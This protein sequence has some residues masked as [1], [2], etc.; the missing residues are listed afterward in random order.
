[1]GILRADRVSGLGG[2]NAINGSVFFG[3]GNQASGITGNNILITEESSDFTF[4]TGDFTIEG[5]FY[6]PDLSNWNLLVGDNVYG[7]GSG[8][9]SLYFN[10]DPDV[11]MWKTGSSVVSGATPTVNTWHHVAFSRESG[12]NRV[13]LDG[14]LGASASDSTNYTSNQILIGANQLTVS[15]NVSQWG[16]K[17]YASNVRVIKGEAIYTAA[18]TAPTTR[19]EK[20][21]NTVL[22]CCQSPGNVLQEE[23]GKILYA[24]NTPVASHFAPDLGEDHGITFEDNTKFDTLSYMVPP[25]GT[26]VESNRGRGIFAGGYTPTPSAAGLNTIS[27]VQIQSLG[28]S[29][30]FGDLTK[31]GVWGGS[32]CASSTRGFH[33]GGTTPTNLATIDYVTIATT[34]N[35]EDFG[36]LTTGRGYTQAASNNT[37]GII[38]GGRGGTPVVSQDTMDYIQFATTGQT[39]GDFGDMNGNRVAGGAL[40]SPTRVLI[41]GGNSGPDAPSTRYATIDRVVISTLSTAVDFGDMTSGVRAYMGCASSSVRGLI[42]GGSIH[43]ARVNNIDYVTIA[44]DGD[45][46]DFGDLLDDREHAGAT[47]NSLRAIWAGGV[48]PYRNSIEYVT[49]TTTGNAQD[50]GDAVHHNHAHAYLSGTSDSHGGI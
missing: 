44:S 34:A 15:T 12:T 26:T 40:A 3:N 13:F 6:T 47:S 7:D 9:W 21:D 5:W 19:L 48:S 17:G 35:A 8:G 37:R 14:A 28:N 25:G 18:F 1:M 50:F 30:D 32:A 27:Y 36:D 16:F 29:I 41:I 20:T 43:P 24:V 2:A 10:T 31:G 46:V 45:S 22:L 38:A 39:A 49:I 42:G 4:G 23:T 11:D 33:C